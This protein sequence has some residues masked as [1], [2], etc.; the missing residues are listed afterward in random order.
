ME[1]GVAEGGVELVGGGGGGWEG[2]V[3]HTLGLKL[4]KDSMGLAIYIIRLI[5]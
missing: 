4:F 1:A 3:G 5:T 2:L